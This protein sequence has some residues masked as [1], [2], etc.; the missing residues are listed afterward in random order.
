M[1]EE[2]QE[3]EVAVEE[4]QEITQEEEILAEEETEKSQE[5]AHEEVEETPMFLE[6]EDEEEEDKPSDS[7]PLATFLREKTKRKERDEELEK[8]R[9]EVE[10][11][12]VQKPQLETGDLKLPQELDFDDPA[13]YQKALSDYNIKVTQRIMQDT[14]RQ[15]VMK[16]EVERIQKTRE[17]ALKN[18]Y[19]RAEKLLQKH[20]ISPEIY[21]SSEKNV[22]EA[23]GIARPQDF[24]VVSDQF[25]EA[26]GEDSEKA[27]LYLGRNKSALAEF[28]MLLQQDKSGLKAAAYLG[29][30]AG[31]VNGNTTRKPS[32]APKPTPKTE[33]EQGQVS[34]TSLMRKYNDAHKKGEIGRAYNIKKEAKKNGFDTSKW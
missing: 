33:G 12:K 20:S 17:E 13:E 15:R 30:V 25:I 28:T 4:V 14:E 27:M 26:V 29:K 11:L 10:Q 7:V 3:S 19:D 32:A 16:E 5:E 22:R 8:L 31:K 21:K 1:P 9:L 18:H 24:D 34:S 2:I 6:T 23:I